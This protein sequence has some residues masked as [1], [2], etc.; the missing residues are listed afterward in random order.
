MDLKDLI[1]KIEAYSFRVLYLGMGDGGEVVSVA[2]TDNDPNKFYVGVDI[3]EKAVENARERLED[4]QSYQNQ[5]MFIQHDATQLKGLEGLFDEIYLIFPWKPNDREYDARDLFEF[6]TTD[7]NAGSYLNSLLRENGQITIIPHPR[8]NENG[9]Y[10]MQI[11]E[12]MRGCFAEISAQRLT[13]YPQTRFGR[14]FE[15]NQEPEPY[16]ITL[17][18]K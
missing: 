12:N 3:Q 4:L 1:E 15:E 11:V 5:I 8:S 17:I 18:K 2:I 14:C 16:C 9:Q 13:D 10:W 7:K 6:L